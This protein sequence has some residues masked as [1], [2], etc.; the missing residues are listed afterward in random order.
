MDP[1]ILRILVLI[2]VFASIFLIAQLAL[3]SFMRGRAESQA[4]NKRLRM[5]ASGA[6]REAVI[7]TLR[8]N[9]PQFNESLPLFVRNLLNR[10]RRMLLAAG[11][12]LGPTQVLLGMAVFGLVVMLVLF[13]AARTTNFALTL[14][15]V[16]IIVVFSICVAV[17]VPLFVI[18]FLAQR[19]R[20]KMEQQFPIAL[21]IFVRALRSD[22]KSVV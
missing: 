6:E 15:V 1:I 7:A 3:G 21:D 5:I 17:A 12:G 13:I 10:F 4:V 20:R 18:N 22:R 16:E 19:R 8:K 9:E 11:L 14:G 2:A